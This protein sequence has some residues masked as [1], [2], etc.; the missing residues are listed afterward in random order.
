[1]HL[2]SSRMGIISVSLTFPAAAIYKYQFQGWHQLISSPKL[3]Q[4]NLEMESILLFIQEWSTIGID[5]QRKLSAAKTWKPLNVAMTSTKA[6]PGG[7][8]YE[9]LLTCPLPHVLVSTIEII[10]S[11]NKKWLSPRVWQ[12]K[13]L[14]RKCKVK[15]VENLHHAFKWT[16]AKF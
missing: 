5:F 6:W 2:C 13:R 3:F 15:L 14:F 1:M 7:S 10:N 12:K 8:P 4:Q 16:C 9:L 11:S